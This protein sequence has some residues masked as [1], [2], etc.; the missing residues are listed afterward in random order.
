MA[1]VDLSDEEV[2][3]AI[4]RP[5]RIVD[6]MSWED[7]PSNSHFLMWSPLLVDPDGATIPGLLV[8]LCVRRGSIGSDCRYDFGLFQVKG[9]R[10]LRAYQINVRPWNRV[11]H[12][13]QG[14][15]W[16]GPHE[17]YGE[18]AA[19]LDSH[20]Q[21]GCEHHLD[22]FELFLQ[23]AKISYTGRRVAPFEASLF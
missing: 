22:W 11:S 8:E 3:E 7:K 17:H 4:A 14:A 15:Q 10:R 18:A 9:A 23:R 2:A 21:F 16:Y 5:K 13:E 19:K 12:I 6:E 20:I 1:A